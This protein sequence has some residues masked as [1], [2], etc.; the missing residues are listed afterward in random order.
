ME[1]KKLEYDLTVCKVETTED[2]EWQQTFSSLVK[3][4]KKSLWFVSWLITIV[5]IGTK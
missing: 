2:I 3:Q 4:M 5:S 1:L